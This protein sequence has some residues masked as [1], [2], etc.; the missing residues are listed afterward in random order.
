MMELLRLE[1][2]KLWHRRSVQIGVLLCFLYIIIFGDLL[3]YQW[4]TFGSADDFT[5]HLATILMAIRISEK[6]RNMQNNGKEI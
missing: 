1:H 4:F 5:V 2:K 6:N 3:S